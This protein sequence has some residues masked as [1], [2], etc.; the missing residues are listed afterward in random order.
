MARITKFGSPGKGKKKAIRR[1]PSPEPEPARLLG[2]LVGKHTPVLPPLPAMTKKTLKKIVVAFAENGKLPRELLTPREPGNIYRLYDHKERLQHEGLH[3]LMGMEWYIKKGKKPG[4]WVPLDWKSYLTM[5]ANERLIIRRVGVVQLKGTMRK[6]TRP[7]L[8]AKERREFEAQTSVSTQHDNVLTTDA[9]FHLTES[10]VSVTKVETTP[11]TVPFEGK[12]AEPEKDDKKKTQNS[13]LIDDFAE[14]FPTLGELMLELEASPHV[15]TVCD[16]GAG[17]R[18]TT[19]RDCTEYVLSCDKCFISAHR[20]NPLHWAQVWD[21]SQGFFVCHDI[22]MLPLASEREDRHFIQLGHGGHACPKPGKVLL[23]TI[24]HVNGIHSTRLAFCECPDTPQKEK[25]ITQLMHARIFPGTVKQPVTG[26]TLAV[27]KEFHLHNLESKKAAYDFYGALKRLT[28]NVFPWKAPDAYKLFLRVVRVYRFLVLLIRVGQFHDIG[29]YFPNRPPGNLVVYCPTCPEPGFNSEPDPQ[30]T[31]FELRRNDEKSTCSY[32]NAVNKQNKKKFKNMAITGTVNCQCS[33]VFVLSSVD[34]QYGERFANTD[35]AIARAL[36]LASIDLSDPE[37]ADID[38]IASYDCNCQFCVN[39]GT[40][41][42]RSE[43]SKVK[44]LIQIFR[45]SIP[46]VH[47]KGHKADCEYLF[48]C[49][50]KQCAAHFHGETA[51]YYWP[52]LNQIGGFI[53][54]MNPGHRHDTIIDCHGDWNWGKKSNA[55]RLLAKQLA[56]ALELYEA[57]TE[58]FISLSKLH[59]DKVAEWKSRDRSPPVKQKGK[60]VESVYRH[61]QSKVPSQVTIYDAMLA[62]EADTNFISKVEPQGSL[63]ALLHEGILIQDDQR[64]LAGAIKLDVIHPLESRKKEVVSRRTKL[65][66]RLT[67]TWRGDQK[68]VMP[69][70]L[71]FVSSQPACPIEKERLYLP[72]DFTL[73]ERQQLDLGRAAQH[74][75][76]LRE[77]QAYDAILRVQS[78]TKTLSAMYSSQVKQDRQQKQN[79]KSTTRREDTELRRDM[80]IDRYNAARAAMI[81]LRSGEDDP[82]DIFPVMTVGDTYMKSTM[83]GRQI[84]ASR[85][86]DGAAM[87]WTAGAMGSGSTL[88]LAAREHEPEAKRRR[89]EG[90]EV[91]EASGTQMPRRAPG[92]SSVAAN[93]RTNKLPL[94]KSTRRAKGKPV[95][96]ARETKPVDSWIWKPRRGK[97]NEEEMKSWSEE[98]D[99][100]QWARAEA[101]ME[102]QQE[103]Y[104]QKL[105]EFKRTMRSFH[106]E[107]DIW[108]TVAMEHDEAKKAGHAAFA[109]KEAAMLAQMNRDCEDKLRGCYSKAEEVLKADRIVNL[110][111]DLR[112]PQDARLAECG[113]AR[114]RDYRTTVQEARG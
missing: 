100:V 17:T 71:S 83:D 60:D 53:R 87:A 107:S 62:E 36:R 88:G 29:K 113:V 110:V 5:R 4:E 67:H 11:K 19:C 61:K 81:A 76:Q 20:N 8:S 34:L 91:A 102:R 112:E 43:L 27:L 82:A 105:A 28:D 3:W 99:R 65:R 109:R 57:N 37:V 40:R 23:F 45:W 47:V 2:S 101:E 39:V 54:Q 93:E 46:F 73:E 22:S 35:L 84:G 44:A 64:R 114:E 94:A 90:G 106:R 10:G 80:Q 26:V 42:G 16:C 103:A 108:K 49:A 12:A 50:Y 68:T 32:L 33:H 92:T 96:V 31:P 41:F 21:A 111:I 70:V 15:G 24:I 55:G 69:V 75:M 77:G 6:R 52:A 56:D 58:H 86:R 79:T 7:Q 14:H 78:I 9:H 66:E 18:T 1:A 104:E 25:R 48:S 51:E 74:E 59:A 89:T 72:S 95:E 85:N 13:Q 63:A 97:M 38:R 30:P 98:G